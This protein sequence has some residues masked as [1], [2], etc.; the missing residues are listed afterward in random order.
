MPYPLATITPPEKKEQLDSG[1]YAA[2]LDRCLLEFDFEK[3]KELQ[4]KLIDGR[5]HG[6]AV[7]CFIEGGAAGPREN[8]RI[9]LDG[10]GGATVYVGSANVGQGL[11]TVC[12]QI[13]AEALDLPMEKIR[14]LHGS[15]THL[16]EGFG[17]F[18]S[19]SVVMMAT[20]AKVDHA[21]CATLLAFAG[22]LACGTNGIK[23]PKTP[24]IPPPPFF[25]SFL[26]SSACFSCALH[27]SYK[28]M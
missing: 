19:R 3:K 1:D 4:G 6:I 8:A 5:Y 11:E 24:G 26:K 28:Y 16:K 12:A 17:A 2:A 23:W 21:S 13:A 9:E 22:S 15:T 20:I 25:S 7:S 14:V 18:H 10:R 27:S